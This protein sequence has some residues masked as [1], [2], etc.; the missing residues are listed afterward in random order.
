MIGSPGYLAPEQVSA[1]ESGA[2]GDVFSLAAVL[3]Y[4]ATGRG[5]FSSPNGEFSPTVLL[6]RIVHQEPNVDGVPAPLVPLLGS[7][8]TKD[9]EQRATPTPSVCCWRMGGRCGIWP[10]LLPDGWRRISPCE[11]RRRAR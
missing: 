3:V 1:G 4:A 10:Q 8:L 11:R 5:P 7:C 6:Y 9:P 2:P